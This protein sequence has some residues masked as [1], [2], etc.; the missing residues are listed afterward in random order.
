MKQTKHRRVEVSTR[1]SNLGRRLATLSFNLLSLNSSKPQY[2]SRN[3]FSYGLN[4]GV[5]KWH[6]EET[7][8]EEYWHVATHCR[9]NRL[10]IL[11]KSRETFN[12][13]F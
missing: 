9:E 11:K 10:K 6:E 4:D 7:K 3:L 2:N 5:I 1:V 13:E 8:D 12:Q